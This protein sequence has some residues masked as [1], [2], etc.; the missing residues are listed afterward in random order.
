M[1]TYTLAYSNN[2]KEPI[3][4]DPYHVNGPSSTYNALPLQ[5]ANYPTEVVPSTTLVFYGKGIADYGEKIQQNL[6]NL[7]ENFANTSSPV[8]PIQGQLWYDAATTQLRAYNGVEWKSVINGATDGIIN[9]QLII[10][11]LPTLPLHIATK[12]YV[13]AAIY[14]VNNIGAGNIAA[15]YDNSTGVLQISLTPLNTTNVMIPSVNSLLIFGLYDNVNELLTLNLSN[16][17]LIEIPIPS[18]NNLTVGGSFDNVTNE[19]HV[20]LSNGANT[21]IPVQP[22]ITR[23]LIII[24]AANVTVTVPEYQLASNRLWIF[25]NGLKQILGAT[26][27]YVETDSTT[28][29]FNSIIPIGTKLELMYF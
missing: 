3:T 10:N 26:E 18:V 28:I 25:R 8:Q 14:S 1:T 17:S 13:D 22:T 4:L 23:H 27:D 19:L 5:H 2:S 7:L 11:E 21:I 24:D 20:T 16:N 29:T 15:T 6:L 9:G 12:D